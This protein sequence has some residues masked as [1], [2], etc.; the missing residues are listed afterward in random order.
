MV[1][2]Q[3]NFTSCAHSQWLTINFPVQREIK[4]P[5]TNEARNEDPG[6]AIV[7]QD[8]PNILKPFG[9]HP[10]GFISSILFLS[11]EADISP[12]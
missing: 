1:V 9:I 8:S 7:Q 6:L 4:F 12:K 11:N 3:K 5:F 10:T 2:N